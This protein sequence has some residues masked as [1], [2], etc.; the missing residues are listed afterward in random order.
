M[1]QTFHQLH[2]NYLTQSSKF[3]S[4]SE[5]GN[6][7]RVKNKHPESAKHLWAIFL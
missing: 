4:C 2:S 5:I 3:R 1:G 7:L 6:D